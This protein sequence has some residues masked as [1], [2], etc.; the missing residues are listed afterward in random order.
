MQNP[1]RMAGS[2][3]SLSPIVYTTTIGVYGTLLTGSRCRL[4][5]FAIDE[6]WAGAKTK[7]CATPGVTRRQGAKPPNVDP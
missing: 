7:S 2:Y 1:L 4:S 3:E 5:P 6:G